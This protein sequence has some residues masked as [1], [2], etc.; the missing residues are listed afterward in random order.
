VLYLDNNE[1]RYT[2]EP[3]IAWL[4]TSPD[5][6]PQPITTRGHHTGSDVAL[7]YPTGMILYDGRH[8]KDAHGWMMAVQ[9]RETLK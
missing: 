4:F 2:K 6:Q 1:D 3:V 9:R 8:Y 7:R 5:D